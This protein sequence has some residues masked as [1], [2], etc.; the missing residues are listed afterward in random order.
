MRHED[1][2]DQSSTI[3]QKIHPIRC[4]WPIVSG[5]RVQNAP[6]SPNLTSETPGLGFLGTHDHKVEASGGLGLENDDLHGGPSWLGRH[7]A[8]QTRVVFG[9][10]RVNGQ[11]AAEFKSAPRGDVGN[12]A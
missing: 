4:L 7:R 5:L 3:E 12:N 1:A 6:G 10:R 2:F 8:Q 9:A 11:A